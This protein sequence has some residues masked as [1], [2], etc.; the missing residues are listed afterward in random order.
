MLHSESASGR[1]TDGEEVICSFKRKAN[2]GG[3]GGGGG[4]ARADLGH[5]GATKGKKLVLMKA[6]EM[7]RAE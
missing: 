7:Q 4:G 3:C 6:G 2:S 1:T 5:R